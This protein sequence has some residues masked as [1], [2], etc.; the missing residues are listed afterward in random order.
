[1]PAAAAAATVGRPVLDALNAR[2]FRIHPDWIAQCA[3]Y[4]NS[5]PSPPSTT[6][7][8]VNAIAHQF[9]HSDIADMALPV[10]PADIAD[11]HRVQLGQHPQSPIVLQVND[12]HEVGV[13]VNAILEAIAEFKPKKGEPPRPPGQVL[14]LPRKMLRMV[15]H[16]GHQQVTAMEYATLP[17]IALD[18]PVGMKV[19]ITGATIRRG[20]LIATPANFKVIGGQVAAMNEH[21]SLHRLENN[22]R[23]A[24]GMDELPPPEHAAVVAGQQQQLPHQHPPPPQ[25]HLPQAGPRPAVANLAARIAPQPYQPP[26]PPQPALSRPR[27]ATA[28][29]P[30]PID[31][32]EHDL[33]GESLDF[34]FDDDDL[35][36]DDFDA[37][38]AVEA[39]FASQTSIKSGS[40]IRPPPP[41]NGRSSSRGLPIKR[42]SRSPTPEIALL[43]SKKSRPSPHDK[44]SG[45]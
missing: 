35:D 37:I 40:P 20:I 8:L 12:V 7:A 31:Y 15:L 44:S 18:S 34:D 4:L 43:T 19:L 6:P 5:M 9:L 38:L 1:M 2:H 39:K 25:P 3:A 23:R 26:L 24:L 32:T 28:A 27:P 30:E 16:D 42:E 36:N 21:G 11:A 13:P 22:C 10:L 29:A 33:F 17:G 45:R 14:R 41:S